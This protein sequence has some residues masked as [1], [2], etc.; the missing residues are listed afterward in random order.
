M[1]RSAGSV[2]RREHDETR[3]QR[4]GL[5]RVDPIVVLLVALRVRALLLDDAVECVASL[6]AHAARR[7]ERRSRNQRAQLDELLGRNVDRAERRA[8]SHDL[9]VASHPHRLSPGAED[10]ARSRL[11]AHE[12]GER[13]RPLV[14]PDLEVDVDD[15]VVRDRDPLQR[16]RDRERTRLVARVEVPDDPHRVAASLDAERAGLARLE[17]RLRCR[18]G[19]RHRARRPTGRS[20]SRP[21]GAGCRGSRS[22]SR[23]RTRPRGAR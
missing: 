13:L 8:R 7:R 16:V 20:A 15:V 23:P 22:G 1:T 21:R 14:A 9:D 12:A 4:M 11:D 10:L 2:A 17:A 19:R 5:E 6:D 18:A 3:P